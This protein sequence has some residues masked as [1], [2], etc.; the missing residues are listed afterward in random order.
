MNQKE[1]LSGQQ[2]KV[3]GVNGTFRYDTEI[4]GEIAIKRLITING[5]TSTNWE[6]CTRVDTIYTVGVKVT[7]YSAFGLRCNNSIL[8]YERM[9]HAEQK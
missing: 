6:F 5:E 9:Y 4:G 3:I 1:F 8:K 7:Q 2:F